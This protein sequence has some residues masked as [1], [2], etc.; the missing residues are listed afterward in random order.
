MV[1]FIAAI[2]NKN[3][4]RFFV[5]SIPYTM[6]WWHVLLSRSGG[7]RSTMLNVGLGLLDAA[8]IKIMHESNW[9]SRQA[10]YQGYSEHPYGLSAWGEFRELNETLS[11]AQFI[12]AKTWLTDRFDNA[13]I[14]QAVKYRETGKSGDT[15]E[16]KFEFS[17][18]INITATSSTAWFLSNIESKDTTGGFMARFII[19]PVPDKGCVPIPPVL[20]KRKADEIVQ[21]LRQINQIKNQTFQISDHPELRKLYEQWYRDTDKRFESHSARELAVPFWGRMRGAV[22]KLALVYEVATAGRFYISMSSLL[23]AI[24][25]M[26]TIESALFDL[27]KTGMTEHGAEEQEVL[28]LI[29]AAGEEGLTRFGLTRKLRSLSTKAQREYLLKLLG[30]DE[31]V[32]FQRKTGKPGPQPFILVDSLFAASYQEEHAS[33]VWLAD[34]ETLVKQWG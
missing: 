23:R 14:P 33:D 11:N 10:L 17:P 12:G 3:N 9:G 1:D 4:N 19:E 8:G 34:P 25:K 30:R 27:L 18:R 15:P 26:A 24:E 22:L 28:K 32:I 6:D 21:E 16:I 31:I 2:L 5:G 7:G 29:T 20:D 13:R